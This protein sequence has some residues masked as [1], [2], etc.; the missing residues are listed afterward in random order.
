MSYCAPRA[1][2]SRLR[3]SSESSRAAYTVAI[4][5]P[6]AVRCGVLEHLERPV[7]GAV[8][9][10]GRLLDQQHRGGQQLP[11]EQGAQQLA[12]VRRRS[13]RV[14]ERRTQPVGLVDDPTD[15]EELVA[16]LAAV[17]ARGP[18]GGE[19]A[20]LLDHVGEVARDGPAALHGRLDQLQSRS[21]PGR[22][23][24]RRRRGDA[25]A[26]GSIEASVRIR[27][28]AGSPRSTAA[29]PKSSSASLSASPFEPSS[30]EVSSACASADAPR[31]ISGPRPADRQPRRSPSSRGRP[32]SGRRRGWLRSS[33]SRLSPT[34]RLASSVASVPTSARSEASA[35]LRSASSCACPWST[36]R[37]AS[38]WACSRASATI[39]SPCSLA[40]SRILPACLRA[41]AVCALYFSSACAG[42]GLGLVELGE[43]VADRLLP[44]RHRPVDRRD[45]EA[46]EQVEQQQER[47]QLDEEGRVGNQEVLGPLAARRRD[48]RRDAGSHGGHP[49][50]KTNSAMKARLMKNIASTRPTVR[51]KMVCRRP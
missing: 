15:L 8:P 26:S 50:T 1:S 45:D 16:D 37:L 23:R 19:D 38:T 9:A 24:R 30:S 46:R 49:R 40:S 6:M 7:D 51:K 31:S 36:I 44:L 12:L 43:L 13:R 32:G 39:W 35:C 48:E 3:S 33:S 14:R 29:T 17:V 10:G 11:T 20:E 28:T 5:S 18:D 21:R 25:F 27:R 4:F 42:V 2:A 47:S 34:M 22:C 41:S